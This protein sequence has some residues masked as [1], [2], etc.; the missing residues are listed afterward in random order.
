MQRYFYHLQCAKNHHDNDGVDL[1][2]LEEAKTEALR[3]FAEV[4]D[5]QSEAMDADKDLQL[6]V[7]DERDLPLLAFTFSMVESSAAKSLITVAGR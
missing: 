5:E 3:Y 1:F 4:L 6:L 7:C 2:S